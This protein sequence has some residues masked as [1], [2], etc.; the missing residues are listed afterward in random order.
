MG[1]VR[2][3]DT[4]FLQKEWGYSIAETGQCDRIIGVSRGGALLTPKHQRIERRYAMSL[5]NATS[6]TNNL[7]LPP[8]VG[9]GMT[10]EEKRAF[11]HWLAGFSDGDGCFQLDYSKKYNGLCHSCSGSYQITLRRDDIDILNQIK[12]FLGCG[13]VRHIKNYTH[14]K[15]F[16]NR[17]LQAR[18]EVSSKKDLAEIIIP[19]FT[20]FPLRSKKA[21]G[22]DIWK[23]AIEFCYQIY[24]RKTR[25]GPTKKRKWKPDEVDYFLS[26]RKALKNTQEY[27]YKNTSPKTWQDDPEGFG[28]WLGGFADAEGTFRLSTSSRDIWTTR[29]GSF[30]ISLR[31][32]DVNILEEIKE[33]LKCGKVYLTGEGKKKESLPNTKLSAVFTIFRK[34]E[35][36]GVLAPLFTKHP[37]RAKKRLDFD[38]WRRGIELLYEVWKRPTPMTKYGALP[39]WTLE[40]CNLFSYLCEQIREIRE[41]KDPGPIQTIKSK[42]VEG[43][44]LL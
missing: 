3:T 21:L 37:L 44:G 42:D 35:L 14:Q 40:E 23:A 8:T 43:F 5:V 20:Q 41:Y 15:G 33:F 29:R 32:D 11:G 12:S 10:E 13:S 28:Y 22:F 18:F 27:E 19:V 2:K 26:L 7:Q 17:K 31:R 4:D 39:K 36:G 38:I 24:K 34:N 16:E 30:G 25:F 9:V 1:S 6:S